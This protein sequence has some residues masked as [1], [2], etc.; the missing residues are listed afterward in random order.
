MPRVP[1]VSPG[2][3]PF[4]AALAIAAARGA[5]T[6]RRS[7]SR[8][9]RRPGRASRSR[10]PKEARAE[11]VTGM[12]YVAISR[13]NQRSPIEQAAPTG[14]PLFSQFV[15]GLAP[16]RAATITA[17]R[18]RPSAREPPR[19]AGRR[20]LD[21]AVRER[22]HALPARGRQDRVAAQRSVG[23]TELEAIAGEPA[24]RSGEGHVRSE[25]ADADPARREQGHS[26]D[27]A[28]RRHR[29]G[30]AD[31]DSERILTKWWGQPMLPR[32]DRAAAE[33]LRQASGRALSRQLRPGPLLARRAR[34]LRPRRR[35]R[36]ALARGRHAA[37]PL[38][39]AAAPVA[40]LRRLLRRE[41]REQRAVRRRHHPG[42]DSRRRAAF[43]AIRE[44]WARMLSG[45]ST[46]GWIAAAHQVFYPDFYGGAVRELPGCGGLLVSPDRRHL[47]GR[48]RVL[49]RQGMD[50]SRAPERAA[51]RRQHPVDDEGRKLVRARRRRQVPIGRP[52]GHLGGHLL[53]GRAGRLSEAALEQGD[54][55]DRQERRRAV[56]EVRPAAHPAR[57][58]GR[59]SGRRSRTS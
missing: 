26:A 57:P 15:E 5:S 21:A 49:L 39:H 33:G 59:R 3:R 10:S 4:L 13:D 30:E 48:E 40:V 22:L 53:A 47:Q 35:V 20:L 14:V 9:G 45:G 38:R 58:T 2:G 32:R 11:A 55:R 43:R 34:R 27:P 51:P 52:V 17:R 6:R 37:V 54:R 46:G 44:P 28:A 12:V 50:E 7:R 41:L 56:E 18:S 19:S 42:A 1:A 29:D 25:V 31:Q 16:E 36:S 23:G 8:R 24:R